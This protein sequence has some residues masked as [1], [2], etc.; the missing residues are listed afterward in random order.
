MPICVEKK[1]DFLVTVTDRDMDRDMD[2]ETDMYT[3]MDMEKDMD[4]DTDTWH[5]MTIRYCP[6]CQ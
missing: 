6:V 4:R 5:S 3:D 2:T 1:T